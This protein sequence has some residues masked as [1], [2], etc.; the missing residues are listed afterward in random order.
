MK[1]NISKLWFGLLLL[2]IGGFFLTMI[3]PS[4]QGFYAFVAVAAIGGFAVSANVYHVKKEKEQLICPLGSDC[5]A[6]ITSRYSKF[7]G[8]RLEYL[9]LAYFV[10]VFIIYIALIISP[11]LL[12]RDVLFGVMALSAAAFLFSSYLLFVQAFLLR[13]WCIWCILASAFSYT[14]FLVSLVNL[15]IAI[16]F[17]VKIETFLVMLEFLGFSLGMGAAT[18]AVFLFYRFLSDLD[19][20]DKEMDTLKGVSEIVWVGLGLVLLS[21]FALYVAYPDMLSQS[22]AFLSKIIALFV[23]AFAGAVLL[24]ILAPY[25]VYIPFAEKPERHRPSVLEVLRK[26]IFIVGAI[27]LVSWY[28]AFFTNFVPEYSLATMLIA[29]GI[30]ITSAIVISLGWEYKIAEKRIHRD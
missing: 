25:L 1:L 7:L 27:A 24:I 6:V 19:I 17:L 3:L 11:G 16:G 8:I 5:N 12:T 10:I 28:F 26:P 18:A 9:G 23:T 29:Y 14:V 20:D 13:Q 22:S 30:A 2:G 4:P 15:P 21:Q